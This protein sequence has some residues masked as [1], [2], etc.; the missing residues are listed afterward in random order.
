MTWRR[1]VLAW[2][3]ALVWAGLIFWLSGQSNPPD[4][5]PQFPFKRKYEH[6]IG[7]A[8]F[9]FLVMRGV[10]KAHALSLAKS[11]VLAVV[12][13][14]AYASSDEYH[15]SF[16]PK[17]HPSVRDVAIDTVGASAGICACCVYESRRRGAGG[18]W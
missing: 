6:M 5:G 15:Q 9:G 11:T 4:I 13:V 14:V 16:V 1:K 3:P 10:R 17:R 2:L 18:A 12:L 8:M 7:Y